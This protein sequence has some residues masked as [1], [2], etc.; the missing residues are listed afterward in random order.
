MI[1]SFFLGAIAGG[2]VVWLWKDEIQ[3]YLD[4]QARVART[5]AADGLRAADETAGEVFDRAG[6][7]LRRA[8]EMLDHGRAQVHEGLRAA[9]RTLRPENQP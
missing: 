7:P 4:A 2:L 3:D 1:R 9:E 8:E 6:A 5:R